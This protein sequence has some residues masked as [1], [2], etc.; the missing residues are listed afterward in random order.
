MGSGDG[1]DGVPD[2]RDSDS[3]ITDAVVTVIAKLLKTIGARFRP[4]ARL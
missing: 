2:S 4:S 1:G 3:R